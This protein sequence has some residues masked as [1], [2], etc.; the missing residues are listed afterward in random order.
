ML[1]VIVY[2]QSICECHVE[3]LHVVRSANLTCS[4]CTSLKERER[5]REREQFGRE[6][7]KITE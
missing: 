2:L 3:E 7:T 4:I 1:N 5:E 6:D